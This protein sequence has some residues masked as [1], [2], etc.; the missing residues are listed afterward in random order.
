MRSKVISWNDYNKPILMM[1][2]HTDITK[3]K[4]IQ[5]IEIAKNRFEN[6]FKNHASVMLY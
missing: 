6:M 1:G 3:K 2:T 4:L 5:E